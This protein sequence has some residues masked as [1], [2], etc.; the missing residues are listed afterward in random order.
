MADFSLSGSKY[1]K[2]ALAAKD[3]FD[4]DNDPAQ[5]SFSLKPAGSNDT[6]STGQIV[7]VQDEALQDST[8]EVVL[9]LSDLQGDPDSPL[10]SIRK[11][12]ELGL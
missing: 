10:Y 11:F 6:P 9:K 2:E 8:F 7:R 3:D 5:P 4:G 12:E 1:A